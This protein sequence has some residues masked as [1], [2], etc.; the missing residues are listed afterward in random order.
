MRGCWKCVQIAGIMN[1]EE[2]TEMDGRILH[3]GHLG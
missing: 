2:S 3:S 1:V